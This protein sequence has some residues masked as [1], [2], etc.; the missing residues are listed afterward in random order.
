MTHAEAKRILRTAV[1]KAGQ[2]L[3]RVTC[4]PWTIANALK[5]QAEL[6]LTDPQKITIRH[7][8]A[9]FHESTAN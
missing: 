8:S 6:V 4:D 3:D 5:Q 2:N 1:L 9:P 7:P